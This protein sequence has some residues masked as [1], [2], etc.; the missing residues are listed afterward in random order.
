MVGIKFKPK[1]YFISDNR[2]V[3]SWRSTYW[4]EQII[5]EEKIIKT[6]LIVYKISIILHNYKLFSFFIRQFHFNLGFIRF[7]HL[8]FIKNVKITSLI[9]FICFNLTNR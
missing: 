6:S 1:E 5:Q 3:D 4:E 7:S 8:I 9:F 2:Y